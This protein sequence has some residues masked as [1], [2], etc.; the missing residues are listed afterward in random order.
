MC[1]E[2]DGGGIVLKTPQWHVKWKAN[3]TLNVPFYKG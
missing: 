3:D 2:G 1:V